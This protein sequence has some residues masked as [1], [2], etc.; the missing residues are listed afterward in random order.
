M[1]FVSN[2]SD[3]FLVPFRTAS[4]VASAGYAGASS[5]SKV[6]VSSV[7]F[8]EYATGVSRDITAAYTANSCQTNAYSSFTD[9]LASKSTC[10][11]SSSSP[12][13]VLQ[14][15]SAVCQGF[16]TSVHY[17]V[18]H[19][20]SSP[21]AIKNVTAAVTITDVPLF[22]GTSKVASFESSYDGFP[23]G[24]FVGYSSRPPSVSVSQSFSV[25]FSSVD[26]AQ[27]GNVNGNVVAR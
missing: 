6:T 2:L 8:T 12:P 13:L 22:T 27:K 21:G 1:R 24:G 5:V 9:Y 7:K 4:T 18:L 3:L 14:A 17:T 26:V 19:S 11:F 10:F 20:S 15:S 23:P 25:S 16:V